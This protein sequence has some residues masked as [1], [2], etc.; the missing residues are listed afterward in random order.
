MPGGVYIGVFPICRYFLCFDGVDYENIFIGNLLSC[1]PV[2]IPAF[3][4]ARSGDQSQRE[5]WL[6]T[7]R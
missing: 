1:R 3:G 5:L 4:V 7:A 6:Y 2:V